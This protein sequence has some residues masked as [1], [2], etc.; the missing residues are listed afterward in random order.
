MR[1]LTRLYPTKY[2]N[3]LRCIGQDLDLRGLRTLDITINGMDYVVRCGYQAPPAEM[4]VT[5]HYTSADLE[6]LDRSWREKRGRSSSPKEFVSLVQIL[7]AIGGYLDKGGARLIRIAN[8]QT[9]GSDPVYTVEYE[10]SDGE[11]VVDDREGA[12]IYDMC[13]SMYK[14]RGRSNQRASFARY[15][16]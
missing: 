10:T 13:V 1:R 12:A 5:L 14:Q 16:R 3:A 2:S 4:P 11:S 7:R 8:N 6:E 15:G 9:S